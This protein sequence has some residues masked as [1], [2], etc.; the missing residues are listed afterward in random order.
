MSN[1]TEEN[2][3][4]Y[5]EQIGDI[6]GGEDK[7]LGLAGNSVLFGDEGNLIAKKNDKTS[8]TGFG[9]VQRKKIVEERLK[10][11]P[12]DK[13]FRCPYCFEKISGVVHQGDG[14]KCPKC[15]GKL[16]STY[17]KYPIKF[18]S[19]I[20]ASGSGKTV[21]LSNLL[22][23]ADR[24]ESNPLINYR[25][26][27][28]DCLF[29]EDE[30]SSFM[31]KVT[32]I[33]RVWNVDNGWTSIPSEMDDSS[34]EGMEKI[35]KAFTEK[36]NK[37][38]GN[39]VPE[40]EIIKQGEFVTVNYPK[41]TATK[42]KLVPIIVELNYNM[43]LRFSSARHLVLYD[44]AGENLGD[45][46][47]IKTCK[48]LFFSDGILCLVSPDDIK[49]KLTDDI[50]LRNASS[51]EDF[52]EEHLKPLKKAMDEKEPPCIL[53][54]RN[55]KVN[56]IDV[57]D[58]FQRVFRAIKTDDGRS[59][60]DLFAKIPLAIALTKSDMYLNAKV[61]LTTGATKLIDEHD[62]IFKQIKYPDDN[63]NYLKSSEA[64]IDGTVEVLFPYKSFDAFKIILQW[65]HSYRVFAISSFPS[66]KKIE[67]VARDMVKSLIASA[68]GEKTDYIEKEIYQVIDKTLEDE[69]FKPLRIEE[70]IGW[71]FYEWGWLGSDTEKIKTKLLK[72]RIL[73]EAKGY[74]FF[75][76]AKY[77]LKILFNNEY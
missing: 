74:S 17:G 43:A 23:V 51:V 47:A 45:R 14:Y 58:N 76:K 59:G 33:A 31:N 21:Y 77:F 57:L 54:G 9:D 73:S 22:K 70:P 46:E 71:M 5:E 20:G 4:T 49:E 48:H 40:G 10:K 63:N 29:G 16:P 8:D 32:Q 26:T 55:T 61:S 37:N 13:S 7:S 69:D 53:N 15:N 42:D 65:Y 3:K 41:A 6:V 18:L 64:D 34:P 19:V 67:F 38:V 1:I 36:E 72:W 27:V 12:G 25:Y 44:I 68:D 56:V 50:M 52:G 66:I 2:K 28:G 30:K 24:V 62:E 11:A 39:I 35:K 60:M 75:E